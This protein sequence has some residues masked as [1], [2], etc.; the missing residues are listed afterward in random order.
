LGLAEQLIGVLAAEWDPARFEDR[1]RER[2]LELI[3]RK[4]GTST[5]LTPE[6]LAEAPA[7]VSDL[8]EALRASVEA[9]KEREASQ[10][11]QTG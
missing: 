10:E 4:A 5:I 11:R 9:L 3:Q 6:T 2:L 8:M 1:D 7:N